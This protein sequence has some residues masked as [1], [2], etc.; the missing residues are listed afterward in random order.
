VSV[1]AAGGGS[2]HVRASAE[3][4]GTRGDGEKAGRRRRIL[5][6]ASSGRLRENCVTGSPGGSFGEEEHGLGDR[7]E[8]TRGNFGTHWPYI[9]GASEL[10]R[11]WW[12]GR[13][14]GPRKGGAGWASAAAWW[15][16][17]GGGEAVSG[18]SGKGGGR[19]GP[20][21]R[22]AG[23]ARDIWGLSISPFP[24]I[25]FYSNLDIAFESKIQIY[26]M[27]LNGCTTTKIQHTKQCI[28][29]I[30]NNQGLF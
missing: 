28:D 30:C 17:R 6:G 23:P 11:G 22:G 18:P 2:R 21:R 26:F 12:I 29:M 3:E 16:G 8:R 10:G 27:S 4:C 9:G 5:A 24:L 14:A 7:D 13:A 25:Y 15:L 19:D 1:P 20:R